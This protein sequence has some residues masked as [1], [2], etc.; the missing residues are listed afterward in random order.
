[1]KP[2]RKENFPLARM[3]EKALKEAVKN[4]FLEH[5]LA[6]DPIA[7]WKNGKVVWIPAEKIPVR[8]PKKKARKLQL[9]L[10]TAKKNSVK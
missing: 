2:S 9:V 8:I 6:G 5:K 7:I 1:M 10:N 4:A 3:A